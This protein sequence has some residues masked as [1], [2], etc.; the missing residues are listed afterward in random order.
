[1]KIYTRVR[2]ILF[3]V[4]LLSIF[5]GAQDRGLIVLD[6]D[7]TDPF[8][9][10]IG[11]KEN[12]NQGFGPDI[13]VQ[14]IK[15]FPDTLNQLL[16][17]GIEGKLNT[18]SN[19]GIGF[20][21]GFS[22][23]TGV[24]AGISLGGDPGG[25]YMGNTGNN[26]FRADFQ[27]D[28]MFAMNPGGGNTDV[29]IDAVGLV[30]TRTGQYLGNCNQSGTPASGP[31]SG[32]LFTMNSL[33]FAFDNSGAADKG[34]EICIPFSE[35][36]VTKAG[37]FEAFA[38]VVSSTA[39]FSDVTV[40]GNVA[41]PLVDNLG[42]NPDFGVVSGGPYHTLAI[43]LPVELTSFSA[44]VAGT[45]VNLNWTTATELN[46]SGFSI[47]RRIN[48]DFVTVGFVEGNGTTTETSLYSFTD[49]VSSINNN[50]KIFYRL[51]QI[52]Y[53]GSFTYSDEIEVVLN[54]VEFNLA[55][56]Y[57]NPFNPSTT[58]NFQLAE[59]TD[60]TLKVFDALGNEV[61]VLVNEVKPA[62]FYQYNF[63]AEGLT[64]GIYF[65]KIQTESFSATKKMLLLK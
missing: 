57:P 36:G 17:V 27:V 23:V 10:T 34:F 43:G 42:F 18:G 22:E 24:N 56:N 55:Q 46:N 3:F 19:D 58:I 8:Y 33:Q 65:Y 15:Y 59:E 64:S 32:G 40:P 54:P 11:T 31:S 49:D 37:T 60:V 21:F 39:F 51:K 63:N 44:N 28:F 41:P 2:A 30:G 9:T 48:K 6:G 1:M 14:K 50:S 62:G 13:D 53:D 52:D 61:A 45:S 4:L 20:W 25:H 35:L 29:F 38:F 26:D 16:Y 47:E 5:I 7:L 12:S